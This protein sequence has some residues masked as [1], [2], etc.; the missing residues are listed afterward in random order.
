MALETSSIEHERSVYLRVS[1]LSVNH[2]YGYYDLVNK[3]YPGLLFQQQV[4][5]FRQTYRLSGNY[6]PGSSGFLFYYPR[7]PTTFSFWKYYSLS[8]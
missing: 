2:P 5:D 4:V 6:R 8:R 1:W 7:L 3:I